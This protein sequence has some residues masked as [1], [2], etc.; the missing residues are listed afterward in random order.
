MR[1]R[2]FIQ[3][4][5]PAAVAGTLLAEKKPDR[6]SGVVKSVDKAKMTVDLTPSKSPNAVRKVM[7]DASTKFTLDGKPA[8]ADA[9]ADSLRIVAV[10]TF[11]GVNLKATEISLKH[12]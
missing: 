3:V 10:G 5:L 9:L 7:F 12:R 4:I 6:L 1:R 8:Q 2:I 11:E